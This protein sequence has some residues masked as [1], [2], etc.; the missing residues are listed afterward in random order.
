MARFPDLTGKA[1]IVAGGPGHT[2][3]VV[4]AFAANGALV[5]IVAADRP[6]VDESVRVAEELDATVV[7]LA[8]DPASAEVW[9][10]VTPHIE[11]RLGPLDVVVVIGAHPVREAGLAAVLPDMTARSRGVLIEVGDDVTPRRAPDGVRHRGIHPAGPGTNTDRAVAAA[12]LLCASD[13]FVTA[14]AIVTLGDG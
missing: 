2:V 7:G 11:Q 5:A 1:V 13:S 6:V 4:R 8:A 12:A 14:S 3:E 10:R 9:A